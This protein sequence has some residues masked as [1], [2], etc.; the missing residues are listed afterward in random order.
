MQ[1]TQT[2][3]AT[4]TWLYC[5]PLSLVSPPQLQDTTLLA[6]LQFEMLVVGKAAALQQH[7]QQDAE[8]MASGLRPTRLSFLFGRRNLADMMVD[9]IRHELKKSAA[10]TLPAE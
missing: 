5:S 9:N 4:F 1:P 6:P 2:G 3:Q 8:V 7:L 10:P